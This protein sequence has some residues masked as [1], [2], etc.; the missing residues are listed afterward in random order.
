LGQIERLLGQLE[1]LL[2]Q[3]EELLGQ[4]ETVQF[5]GLHGIT[6]PHVNVSGVG[7]FLFSSMPFT[8]KIQLQLAP[9]VTMLTQ[10]GQ[11]P[12]LGVR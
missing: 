7:E 8:I 11:G 2:W 1:G 5:G 12:N 6:N 4:F 10:T 3:F 9:P